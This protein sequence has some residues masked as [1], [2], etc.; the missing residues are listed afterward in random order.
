MSLDKES[1]KKVAS[2]ARI[3][4]SDEEL[5]R[6]MPQLSKIIGFVEQLAEVNTD[7]VE[8]LANVVDITPELRKDV[9]NDGGYA[10]KI[11]E[12]APE[13]TQ[14]YFVVPKVVE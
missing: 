5:E 6:M 9:V 1:V 14:G 3:R 8:P 2:L 11:L 7:N 4:M 10:D 12:N 13:E